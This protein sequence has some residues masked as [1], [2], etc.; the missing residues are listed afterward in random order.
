MGGIDNASSQ[1]NMPQLNAIDLQNW[2]PEFG[3]LSV[4]GGYV[5]HVTGMT[6]NGK[7]LMTFTALDGTT[8]LFCCTD[9]GVFDVTSSTDTPTNVYTLTEGNVIW[10]QFSNLAG[11]WL[12]G[13]NGVDPAFLYDGTN[14]ISFV[15]DAA[16]S[17]PGEIETGTIT[18][19]DIAYVHVHK[20]RLWFIERD[21]LTAWYMPLNA[22]AGTP[23][24]FPLG[25]I[26]SRGGYLSAMFS[27]S[28]DSGVGVDDLMVFQTSTGEVG[29]YSGADP[30]SSTDW[31]LLARYF[32]GSPL[33]RKTNEPLNGDML[34]TT[35]F[36][37]VSLTDVVTGRYRMGDMT[38]TVS[39]KVNRM[40]NAEVRGRSGSPGWELTASPVYQ[41]VIL[42]IP[43]SGDLDAIQF[44]MNSVTGSWTRFDLPALALHEHA[45]N[46]YFTDD[47]GRVL[48]YGTVFLDNILLDGSGGSSIV[49]AMQQAFS[50][51]ESPTTNKHYKFVKPII[52]SEYEPSVG[53]LIS[54]DYSPLTI[55][56][57]AT[58]GISA[59]A[60]SVLW[61]LA[62]WDTAIWGQGA[63]SWQTIYGVFGIGYAASIILKTKTS[64]PTR[65]VATH[66]VFEKGISM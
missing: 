2:F 63:V 13:C 42:S 53:V 4:R 20:N 15:N 3:A 65:F 48:K 38:T 51:F 34:V 49:T 39:G 12:V 10:T 57:L 47:T 9:D 50:S 36:G 60:G 62:V 23:V 21:T 18:V 52:D 41:Y 11:Q 17:S 61:D 26:F 40:I 1:A 27:F 6:D 8:E 64:A 31:A 58:P 56:S 30:S 24:A 19:S 43:A 44:I 25:G 33:G 46:L 29:G 16:P 35:E 5:E 37:I 55:D 22:V 54:T 66:W 28:L 59:G 14:W 45:Q 32:L 7:T